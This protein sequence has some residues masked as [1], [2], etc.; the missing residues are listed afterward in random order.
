VR[1]S[2]DRGGDALAEV[3]RLAQD[4]SQAVDEEIP[5]D[6]GPELDEPTTAFQEA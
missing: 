4:V 6:V 5:V 3:I 1:R 2:R